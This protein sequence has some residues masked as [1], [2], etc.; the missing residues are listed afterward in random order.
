MLR[1]SLISTFLWLLNILSSLKTDVNVLPP[2]SRYNKLK[3]RRKN[4]L[5]VSAWKSLKKRARFGSVSKRHGF[6]TLFLIEE[7]LY[8]KFILPLLRIQDVYPGYEFFPSRIRIK[9]FKYLIQ[10]IVSIYL[11]EICYVL[12]IPDPGVKKHRI[13]D[14][15][16]QHCIML[17]FLVIS[18]LL[19]LKCYVMLRVG[20]W[21]R[22]RWCRSSGPWIPAW[23]WSRRTWS[24]PSASGS[25]GSQ[26]PPPAGT[27]T[28]GAAS[29]GALTT[30]RA[31]C[32][33]SFTLPDLPN[34]Y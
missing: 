16:P 6:K 12:F 13:P 27:P 2:V 21:C 10:K 29:I 31:V 14:S 4:F 24:A 30:G 7:G 32:S 25:S 20:C 1:K 15:V 33:P 17:Q 26:S 23:W 18:P 3:L 5:F 34:S 11:S 28:A 22:R 8:T 9:V 19:F